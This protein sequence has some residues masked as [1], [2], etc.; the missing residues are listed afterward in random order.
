M[1]GLY[2]NMNEFESN[3]NKNYENNPQDSSVYPNEAEAEISSEPIDNNQ[4]P[5]ENV[6]QDIYSASSFES[7]QQ[8]EQSASENQQTAT[9]QNWQ[10]PQQDANQAQQTPPTQNW[11]QPEHG[12][13]SYTYNSGQSQFTGTN[14]YS[15]PTNSG[16]YPYNNHYAPKPP[17]GKKTGLKVFAFILAAVVISTVC[18]GFG[19]MVG[20]NKTGGNLPNSTGNQANW[21]KSQSKNATDEKPDENGKYS[22]AAV[23]QMVSPSVVGIVIY[24]DTSD[25][26]ASAS[27]V[28]I[29]DQG[30]V[31]TN[32]HIYSEIPNAKF[33]ITTSDN[34]EFDATYVAGD[35]KSDI[36]V[37]KITNPNN[38]VPAKFGNSDNVK[39]GDETIAIGSPGGLNDTVTSGIVSA[40][41]R[42]I[43]KSTTSG[44][45]VS[46][47]FIQTDTAIN[48]GNSGGALVDRF[49]SVIGINSMKIAADETYEGLG[50]AIPSN[51]AVKI[52]D[53]LIKYGSVATRGRLGISY[54]QIDTLTSR[55]HNLTKGLQVNEI[56]PDSDLQGKGINKE[57]VIVEIDGVAAINDDVVLDVVD[58]K[59]AGE[60]VTLKLVRKSDKKEYTVTAKL[61]EDKG[62]SSYNTKVT[63]QTSSNENPFGEFPF[64]Q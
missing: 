20:S 4:I 18:L 61:I 50:F 53:E 54:S 36:A 5:D 27:G 58:S 2:K 57:D 45:S 12:A 38:L 56:S 34:R 9:E 30:Y 11:Q 26:G 62:T 51:T 49:G 59:K 44:V 64:G 28:I 14:T 55:K 24:S 19:Y 60:S 6:E 3:E 35:Q 21:N 33:L 37:L 10:Q 39:V 43:S 25:T 29:D 16:H 31:L 1:K 17:K 46:T 41:N 23:A 8:P 48:H 15:T 47:K 40:V 52:A 42:R 7:W 22:A 63:E 13:Y 32:D